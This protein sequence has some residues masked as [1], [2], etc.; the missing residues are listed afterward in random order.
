MRLLVLGVTGAVTMASAAPAP[1]NDAPRSADASSAQLPSAPTVA[2]QSAAR[3]PMASP[4]LRAPGPRSLGARRAG[5]PIVELRRRVESGELALAHD[6]I[7]GYLPALLEALDIPLSSQMLVFSRTSLQTDRIAPWA[8]RALYFND[9]V[10]VGWV[11]ESPIIEIASIDPA[12]GARFYTLSQTDATAP[13]FTRETTTCLM[14]HE[15][16]SVTGGVPGLI[17]RSVLADRLGYFIT[18]VHS[19][20]TTDRTP[21]EDRWGGWYVTGTTGSMSHAGNVRAPLLT[22]EVPVQSRYLAEVDLTAGA[23]VTDLSEQFYVDAYLTPHSDPAAIMV[24]THQAEVH[25]LISLVQEEATEALRMHELRIRARRAD[26]VASDSVPLELTQSGGPVERL[27]RTL[28]FVDAVPLAG[29]VHGTST[30]AEDFRARGPHDP[31]G[32]TLRELDLETRLFRYPLSFMIHSASFDALPLIAKRIVARRVLDV[33]DG[34]DRDSEFE[35]LTVDDREAI[36]EILRA[37][38]P[39]LVALGSAE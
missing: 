25:N 35:H 7:H 2:G 15:S 36:L 9:Q 38:E 8:P 3:R 39:E 33:L 17:V 27:V 12:R 21:F 23:N 10:Y 26:A 29:P 6:S 22:H 34:R 14:C 19:G 4:T 1:S 31:E 18:E 13:T 37:T 30:F 16:R 5:D 24:L 28:L 32:R 11:Q 20:S